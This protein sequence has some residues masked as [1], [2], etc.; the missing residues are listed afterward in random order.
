VTDAAQY[1]TGPVDRLASIPAYVAGQPAPAGAYK[2]SSNENPFPPLPAVVAAIVD[3][4]GD[5]N[6]YP[7]FGTVALIEAIASFHD[8]STAQVVVSTGSVAVLQAV[9]SAFAGPGDEIVYPWRSFEAYPIVV[10]VSGATP[11]PV[12][13][14]PDERHA[15]GAMRDCLNERTKVVLLCSPNNPTGT[16]LTHGEVEELLAAIPPHV[17]VVLDEAYVEFVRDADAVRGTDLLDEHQ[18]LVVLRTFSKAYALAGLRVGYA[19]ASPGVAAGIRKAQTP[20]GVTSLAE[21]AAIAALASQQQVRARVD[22]LVAEREAVLEQ[23]RDQGWSVP[24]SHG[25]FV[26]LRLGEQTAEFAAACRDA[27]VVV[28]A[29]AGEGVRVTVGELE[30]NRRFLEVSA[31]WAAQTV[32]PSI[33]S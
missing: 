9:C 21:R 32:S 23:L 31:H 14:L 6:R 12:G 8:V 4:A 15:I 7:D 19:L 33:G 20:F 3:G 22:V 2:L 28:R 26:W 1:S 13:L 11:C 18:N 24:A 25:N 10:A 16:V 17:L 5:V 29:F 27:G 30:A